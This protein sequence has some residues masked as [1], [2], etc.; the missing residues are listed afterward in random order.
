MKLPVTSDFKF[1]HKCGT[2]SHSGSLIYCDLPFFCFFLYRSF[3][4]FLYHRDSHTHRSHHQPCPFSF[5]LSNHP[6]TPFL[7][8]SKLINHSMSLLS[9][10]PPN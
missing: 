6:V 1:G 9:L 7:C 8:F 5:R 10:S 2:Y 3:S 4:L